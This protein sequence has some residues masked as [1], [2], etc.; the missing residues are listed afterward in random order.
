MK[1][2][3]NKSE[4]LNKKSL[5][6][7]ILHI[8][9]ENPQQPLN[10]KQISKRL[11]IS[12]VDERQLVNIVLA[13]MAETGILE[14]NERGKFI[15][16]VSRGN[17]SGNIDML[18]NG[19]ATL[20]T[21]D[22][23]DEVFI[24]QKNLNHAMNGDLVR[25]YVYAHRKKNILEGEVVEIIKRAKNTY[26]GTAQLSHG[27]AFVVPDGKSLANDIF[28]PPDKLKGVKDGQKVIASI[29]D[30]PA[31]NKNPVGEII[32]VLGFAGEHAVEMN[33]IMAEFELPVAFPA[34]VEEEAK[35]IPLKITAAEI[36]KRR[37]FR[38]I[39]TFTIDPED[40]KDFDDALSIQRLDN[41]NYEIGVH[42]AD[43]THYVDP[44]SLLEKEAQN[45]ATSVYL[46]D[47]V[48]PMLPE[49]LSNFLC[50]LR[51][52]EDKLCFSAVFEITPQ[53][54]V[55]KEWF[56][57]TIICSDRR[58]SYDEA[59]DIIDTGEGDF[60][61]DVLL[62]NDLAK[63]LR[64]RRFKNGA[65]GF[66]KVEFKFKLD[67]NGKP[68]GVYTKES[69][70]AHKLIE[71]FMLLA[72][73]Y[74][75]EHIG[76]ARPGWQPHTFVYRIHDRPDEQKLGQFA[77]F[78]KQFGYKIKID[79]NRAIAMSINQ[80]I[81]DIKG[82]PEKEMIENLAIRSMAKAEYSTHNIG[83]YGLAFS[84]YSHFTSPIRRY[85]D[86]MAHRLLFYY[87]NDGKNVKPDVYEKLCKHSSEMEQKSA[88]AERASVKYK[89]AEFLS[90]KIGIPFEGIISGVT[91]F[92]IFV[93]LVENKCEGLVPLRN[94]EDDFYVFD[95]RRMLIQGKHT[96]NKYQ[97][98][99]KVNVTIQKVN[100]QRRQVDMLLVQDENAE[101][102]K[103]V[104]KANFKRRR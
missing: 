94:L 70:D 56:G 41:G 61:E 93:Q 79:G 72:N 73:K 92:G 20:I 53:A 59:Q 52:K 16:I 9:N 90:D 89:Q 14:E 95:N 42:I 6:T 77:G 13:E 36:K 43:V 103:P 63:Q 97:L 75:A 64:A 24:S 22:T 31:S 18:P 80:L 35:N 88:D 81:E 30:W 99:D 23:Q 26:V 46:V 55:V 29:T 66:E 104:F 1:K 91:E 65:L 34:E 5:K 51:P 74:V 85:P 2:S 78:I 32:E 12:R 68:L 86:M 21:D 38:K 15:I 10:Y 47:R 82:K 7:Q 67:E 84:Y 54:G 27:F 3:T 50:S 17:I 62:L 71:E 96:G 4:S 58:F 87:L 98:G 28:I 25:V 37:D 57:K 40:A 83:H 44:E 76:K 49:N 69:K 39:T 33:A 19:S 48:I 102:K 100:L 8:F 101:V 11:S 60:K 45:R